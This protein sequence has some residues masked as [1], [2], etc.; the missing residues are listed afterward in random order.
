M[1]E[2][3]EQN[4]GIYLQYMFRIVIIHYLWTIIIF[5]KYFIP[6]IYFKIHVFKAIFSSYNMI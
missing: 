1:V 2:E 3:L 6:P 5:F 4:L